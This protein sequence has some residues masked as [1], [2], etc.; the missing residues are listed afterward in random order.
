MTG[1]NATNPYNGL[2]LSLPEEKQDDRMKLGQEDFLKLMTTQVRNQNPLEPTKDADFIAQMAQFGTVS[3]IEDLQK[4]FADFAG[5]MRSEQVLQGASLV[6]R[7]V[8][9]PGDISTKPTD[10]PLQG[11]V[12]VPAGVDSVLVSIQAP[13]GQSIAQLDLGP[14]SQGVAEFQWDGTTLTGGEAPAGSY[15]INASARL[16]GNQEAVTTYGVGKVN[17]VSI[18][19]DNMMRLDVAG[20]SMPLDQVRRIMN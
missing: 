17:S 12:D 1:V 9:Y 18:G 19:D 6:N 5:A 10:G 11:A 16:N 7:Q 20:T 4:S 13:N 15:I 3:G 2:G 8:M 14:Q